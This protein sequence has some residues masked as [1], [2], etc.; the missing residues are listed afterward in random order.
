ML[1]KA[2]A[3]C[4]GSKEAA[5]WP[6]SMLG[7]YRELR[8]ASRGGPTVIETLQRRRLIE[9]VNYA[10]EHSRF[11]ADLYQDLPAFDG[12]L[13]SLPIVS[14][15]L[16]MS[17]FNDWVTD[18]EITREKIDAFIADPELAGH[19]FLGK[20][21]VFTTSGSS[22]Y[23]AILVQPPE[24]MAVFNALA[25]ARSAGPML[26]PDVLWKMLKG[27][28]KAAAIFVTG[29]H[30][31]GNVMMH[32]RIMDRPVRRKIQKGFSAFTPLPEL[33]AQLN[34]FKPVMLGGYASILTLL[35][36]EKLRGRLTID[37]A[38]VSQAGETL[39]PWMREKIE[40]AFNCPITNSYSASEA[41]ALTSE[42]KL[43]HLHLN[44]DW[45]I[46]EPVDRNGQVVSA[47]TRSHS[48]LVTNLANTLQPI[49][50][51]E[52]GDCVTIMPER[53]ACGSPFPVIDVEGRT[54]EILSFAGA[55]QGDLV[56]ILPLGLAT[57]IEETPQ[58]NRFQV[59]QTS[60]TGLK[61]RVEITE[62]ADPDG[63]WQ[64][65]C[66]RVQRYFTQQNTAPVTIMRDA[67]EPAPDPRS[68]KFRHVFKAANIQ[69][70][71]EFIESLVA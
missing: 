50:R 42:C 14:K 16:L 7:L 15:R 11:Y 27:G 40:A 2:C 13:S 39:M 49:I 21:M 12:D 51:Y 59:I 37:P 4:K 8:Q 53:C 57:V 69:A 26:R 1:N 71:P 46:L 34:E 24:A 62:G 32:R 18:P 22:G 9:M 23:P 25:I 10:R 29:G 31:G 65:V 55:R 63:V 68:G 45:Y 17:R 19:K 52:L 5:M 41:I 48:A 28:F 38:L 70:Q 44:S 61:I 35:A 33:V 58:L 54:D 30:F 43:G 6:Q 20:Y 36:E 47:S 67:L 64:G 3:D 60:P 66:E 56:Q